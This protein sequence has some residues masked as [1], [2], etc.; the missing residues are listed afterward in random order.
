MKAGAYATFSFLLLAMLCYLASRQ[1]PHA[2][3]HRPPTGNWGQ[4]HSPAAEECPPGT[5]RIESQGFFLECYR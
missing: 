4:G 1:A 3:P 2:L 5:I